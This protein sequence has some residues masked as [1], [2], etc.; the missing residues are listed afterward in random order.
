MRVVQA[1]IENEL[2]FKSSLLLAII[3]HFLFGVYFFLFSDHQGAE[4]KD[5]IEIQSSVRVDLVAMPDLTTK[6]ILAIKDSVPEEVVKEDDAIVKDAPAEGV[7]LS[8]LLNDMGKKVKIKKRKV[9]LKGNELEVGESVTGARNKE[10]GDQWMVYISRL[11][12]FV[13][14]HWKLPSYLKQQNLQARIRIYVNKSGTLASAKIIESSGN[15]E[16]DQMAL[17][18]AKL[19][20]YPSPE[21]AIAS[22]L[23]TEGAILG[24]PL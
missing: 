19:A 20:K 10:R 6:E 4:T 8:A 14:P 1:N 17:R 7:N 5:F 15:K 12:S 24:F 13:R 23:I 11:P 18:A 2:D 21:Q 9:A 16:Y 3:F 22:K